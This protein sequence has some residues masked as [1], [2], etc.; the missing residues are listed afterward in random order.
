MVKR[1]VIAVH[2]N[3]ASLRYHGYPARNACLVRVRACALL[4]ERKTT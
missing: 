3:F 4:G 1:K 2:R